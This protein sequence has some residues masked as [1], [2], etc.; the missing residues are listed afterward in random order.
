VKI[1]FFSDLHGSLPAARLLERRVAELAPD[2]IVSLGDVL[3]DYGYTRSPGPHPVAEILNRYAER[4]VAVRGNCDSPAD[5]REFS[6]PV[7]ADAVVPMH[8]GKV[9][10]LLT[11]GQRWHGGNPPPS[12]SCDVLVHGHTH[13]PVLRKLPDGLVIFN[14][15][16]LAFPRGGH[17]ATFGFF[18][19]ET[20]SVRRLSD[21]VVEMSLA[22]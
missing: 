9:L 6:F 1:L 21:G 2:R 8:I 22:L 3:Y 17:G 18:D 7:A 20:L 11:H 16:A 19:G 15:G 5:L 12:G 14:P 13:V 10:F 4:M